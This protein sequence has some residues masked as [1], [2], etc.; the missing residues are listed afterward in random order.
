[1]AAIGG[2]CACDD[3]RPWVQVQR[4]TFTNWVNAILKEKGLSVEALEDEL[5]DG[6]ILLKL[7]ETLAPEK[8]MPGR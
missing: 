8:R 5:E 3:R 2:A 6:V 1:M 4:R 7:L